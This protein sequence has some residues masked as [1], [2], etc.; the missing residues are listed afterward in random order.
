MINLFFSCDK[1]FDDVAILIFK[2]LTIE[3]YLEGDSSNVLGG[4]YYSFNVFG[5]EIK[6]ERN[7]YDYEEQYN[8]MIHIKENRTNNLKI[9]P[10]IEN[11]MAGIILKL[12]CNNLN[13]PL[14]IEKGNELITVSPSTSITFLQ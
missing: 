7:S 2:S 6:L 10:N 13:I 1:Q 5:M 3:N 4:Y 9:D 14:A 11:I 8:Y 12:L